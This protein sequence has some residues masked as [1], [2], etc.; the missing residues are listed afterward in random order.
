MIVG[1]ATFV[2]RIFKFKTL[3]YNRVSK[4]ILKRTST[5][6]LHRNFLVFLGVR[7][8]YGVVF[9]RV[10]VRGSLKVR[11]KDTTVVT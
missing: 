8:I 11:T 1:F 2:D 9:F 3:S 5:F 6:G 4:N 10:G 7:V